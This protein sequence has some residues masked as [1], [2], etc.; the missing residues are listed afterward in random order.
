MEHFANVNGELRNQF[1]DA[2]SRL[3]ASVSILT[4]D[5]LAGKAG[6]TVSSLTSVSADL[7]K[8]MILVCLHSGATAS[9]AI[10]ENG[11]FCA[12]ILADGDTGIANIFAG[13]TTLRHQS[14]FAKSVWASTDL[15]YPR[16]ELALAALDCRI[17]QIERVGSH[18]VA[19]AE[20]QEIHLGMPAHSLVYANRTYRKVAAISEPVAERS[21]A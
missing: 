6:M 18:H 12:N 13:R 8:P 5:G 14:R 4:T 15:G 3:A 19:F 10:L 1:L 20:V 9:A 17:T 16:Y 7:P 11:G 21:A 2:M